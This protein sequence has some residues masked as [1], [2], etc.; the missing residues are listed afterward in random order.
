MAD[1]RNAQSRK[2]DSKRVAVVKFDG[3]CAAMTRN[4]GVSLKGLC[5]SRTSERMKEK[6]RVK[7]GAC[8][9]EG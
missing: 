3:G 9:G 5:E 6:R 7:E 2:K 8:V 1:V 4:E